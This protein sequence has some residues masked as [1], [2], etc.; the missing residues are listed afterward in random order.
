VRLGVSILASS[1]I[2]GALLYGLT[3]GMSAIISGSSTPR[4]LSG[5]GALIVFL[6]GLVLYLLTAVFHYLLIT[7]EISRGAERRSLEAEV[8][9]RSSELKALRA[10]IDPHFLFN[11]L[12][13]IS[14]LIASDQERARSMTILLADFF[15]ASVSAGRRQSIPLAEEISL[16]RTY[17]EIERVRH[18]DRLQLSVTVEDDAGLSLVPPLV[19]QPL[20]ENA[21]KHG[22]ATLIGGGEIRITAAGEGGKI[23]VSIT[24]P[25]DSASS[26]RK[27]EGASF[28]LQ[29]VRDR[30]R[31]LTGTEGSL[32]TSVSGD[33]FTATVTLPRR[34]Q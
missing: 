14:A 8:L 34:T 12:N 2:G 24:N 22:I 6:T 15:R 33:V 17:L 4:D 26:S 21:I 20:V 28:G 5:G 30:V 11:S 13:S 23:R 10:Q 19:L 18:G 25:V 16:I 9:A 3:L 27:P 32:D 1:V 7:F 29:A 31:A